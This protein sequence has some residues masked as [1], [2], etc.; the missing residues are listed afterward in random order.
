MNVDKPGR[1]DQSVRVARDARVFVQFA[2]RDDATVANADVGA[3]R[4]GARPVD[5]EFRP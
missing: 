1:N 4:G 2:D 5:H 3:T